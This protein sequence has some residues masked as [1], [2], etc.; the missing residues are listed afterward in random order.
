M[1]GFGKKEKEYDVRLTENQ[2]KDLTSNMS[3]KELK[4]F[5]QR[6]KQAKADRDWDEMMMMDMFLD[7]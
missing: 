1:F 3:K 2:I 4:E 7:D 5:N 6:Q